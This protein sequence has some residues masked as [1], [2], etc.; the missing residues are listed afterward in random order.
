MARIIL[1]AKYSASAADVYTSFELDSAYFI[2]L[3]TA[4]E[5]DENYSGFLTDQ[6]LNWLKQEITTFNQMHHLHHLFVLGHHPLF[7]T[8]CRSTEAMLNI[9]VVFD[10][11]LFMKKG[12]KLRCSILI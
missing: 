12:L 10:W 2:L 4:R 9:V 3:D 8:T 1:G 6:Q 11:F 5:K 7:A